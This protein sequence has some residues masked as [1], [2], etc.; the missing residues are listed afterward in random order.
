MMKK[1]FTKQLLSIQ[2]LS[3]LSEIE[4][5]TI[6]MWEKRY[7][8]LTPQR[9]ETNIRYYTLDDLKFL[10]NIKLLIDKNLK[11]SKIASLSQ[12]EI[13][14]LIHSN[15]H[16]DFSVDTQVKKMLVDVLDFDKDSFEKHYLQISK[17]NDFKKIYIDYIIPL[18]HYI[19][20]LWQTNSLDISHEHF[21]VEML[22]Q[23]IYSEIDK[24][25]PSNE[26]ETTFVLF[27]PEN[28]IH[29]IGLLFFHYLLLQNRINCIM[30]GA[31][32]PLEALDKFI[33]SDK[34]IYFA[35]HLSTNFRSAEIANFLTELVKSIESTSDKYLWI[36]GNDIY[37]LKNQLSSNQ[38]EFIGNIDDLE[39]NL[40]QVRNEK[41][42]ME[43][44]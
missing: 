32:I 25:K 11:I 15:Y 41:H 26:S 2:E 7:H 36:T 43:L 38:I 24:L 22:K 8:I 34:P 16:S 14:E 31:T 21:L 35:T 30:L 19:G 18:L 37:E 29:D 39:N 13:E 28:E 44:I 5:G 4:K 20:M 23:K 1:E 42:Q 6:R 9:T 12:T 10:L 3:N 27:L 33:T 40:N 17:L